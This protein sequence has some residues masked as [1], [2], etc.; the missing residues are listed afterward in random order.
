MKVTNQGGFGTCAVHAFA[1]CLARGMLQKYDIAVDPNALIQQVISLV[2]CCRGTTFDQL[3]NEWNRKIAEKNE[4]AGIADMDNAVRYWISVDTTTVGTIDQAWQLAPQLQ[5]QPSAQDAAPAARELLFKNRLFSSGP[6]QIIA[7]PDNQC[8]VDL[9]KRD[10]GALPQ[11]HRL[12]RKQ[13][14]DRSY[15]PCRFVGSTCSILRGRHLPTNFATCPRPT[16]SYRT[17]TTSLSSR[18]W[19]SIPTRRSCILE[20]SWILASQ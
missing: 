5:H 18:A 6:D 1:K 2:A 13:V 19:R 20:L 8:I 11:L 3:C 7:G 17:V 10:G 4:G 15:R 14:H 9:Y 16:S 12:S